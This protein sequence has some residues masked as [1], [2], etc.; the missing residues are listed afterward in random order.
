MPYHPTL[1]AN[2]TRIIAAE[3]RGQFNGLFDLIQTIPVG[4]QG[5]DGPPF[6]NFS[7]GSVTTLAPGSMASASTVFDGTNVL[8]SFNLPR[9]D[10]GTPGLNGND[11]AVGPIGPPFTNFVVV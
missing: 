6:T 10:T 8:I 4:P 1:P 3:L 9:G 5:P 11:G 7:I 2:S